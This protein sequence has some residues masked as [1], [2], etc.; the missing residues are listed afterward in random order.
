MATLK[1][2]NV[3]IVALSACVPKNISRNED[4]KSLLGDLETNKVI[5]NIGIHEKRIVD[6]ETTA[7]DL[8]FYAAEKLLSDNVIDKESIDVLI[9]MS[10]LPDYKIPATSPSLQHRLGLST[11]TACFDISLACSGYVYGLATAYSYACQPSINRVLF[12]VGETFSKIISPQDKVNAPL[13]GDAGTATLIE[14]GNFGP[15]NFMLFSDG[16]G[17]KAIYIPAGGAKKMTNKHSLDV[18]ERE[19]GNF[20]ND[21][22]L[23]MDGLEVFN[24]TLKAVPTSIKEIL[25][26]T[27]IS[28][29]T[30]DYFIF[31]QANK[32]MIDFFIK[33]LKINPLKAPISLNKFGNVSSAT[34]PLTIVTQLSEHLKNNNKKILL[35]GFG[36]GLSWGTAIL[37][38]NECKASTLIEI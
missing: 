22:Q 25:S 26:I 8:C 15:S 29:E 11:K 30:L 18:T 2:D 3:G 17:E 37:N 38:L 24:F 20:R 9:F 36:A 33:K 14:K 1:F 23:F 16:V 35:S 31:H 5:N 4:L 6:S 19:D 13:Y 21:N 34:I 27:S 32:F 28:I 7:S 12:L 10:Q